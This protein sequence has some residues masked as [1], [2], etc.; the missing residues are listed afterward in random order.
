MNP[1]RTV[2]VYYYGPTTLE[3]VELLE[4]RVLKEKFDLQQTGIQAS[5]ELLAEAVMGTTCD[6]PSIP[7]SQDAIRLRCHPAALPDGLR[8][9]QCHESG[10]LRDLLMQ[11]P[12][13]NSA[14]AHSGR[15]R[16]GQLVLGPVCPRLPGI[17][18][19]LDIVG[20]GAHKEL[21]KSGVFP[22][23]LAVA[24]Q[25]DEIREDAERIT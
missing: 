12:A 17:R 4:L 7:L 14:Q 19:L 1:E 20:R 11:I 8:E 10:L 16:A 6:V 15:S 18:H 5:M 3:E 9:A 21:T 13:R 24:S 22:A 25:I 23:R 2:G